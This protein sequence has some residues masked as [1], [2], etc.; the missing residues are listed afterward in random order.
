MLFKCNASFHSLYLGP[1]T[2]MKFFEQLFPELV[3]SNRIGQL[4]KNSFNSW[5]PGRNE[6]L[7]ELDPKPSYNLHGAKDVYVGGPAALFS[8]TIQVII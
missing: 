2:T 7:I 1:E 8:A 6:V 4:N 3:E 5:E